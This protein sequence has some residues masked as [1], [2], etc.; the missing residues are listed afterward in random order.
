MTSVLHGAWSACIL[1]EIVVD[2]EV[3]ALAQQLR[4]LT[5]RYRVMVEYAPEAIVVLDL[6]DGRFVEVNAE[7][8][9]LFGRTR[10]ELLRVGPVQLS[11]ALQPD[12]RASSVAAK[13]YLDAAFLGSPQ[14][15]RL[16]ARAPQRGPILCRV[17]LAA[18]PTTASAR[19]VPASWTSPSARSPSATARGS[20]ASSTRRPTSSRWP[21]PT[22]A[23]CTSTPPVAAARDPGGRGLRGFAIGD[24]HSEVPT[25]MP[26]SALPPRPCATGCGR[27]PR[28][29][30]RATAGCSRRRRS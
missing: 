21:T 10:E 19:S 6:D 8:T 5:A 7:A 27:T 11:P 26:R 2:A 1:L 4:D 28:S 16:A 22:A 23:P 9:R 29:S 13:A 15:L 25:R 18:V 3:R 24:F 30:A 12:G 20:S 14:A 17:H